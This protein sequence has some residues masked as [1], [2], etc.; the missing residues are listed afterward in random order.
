MLQIERNAG[1]R[2][3]KFG[4]LF[5]LLPWLVAGGCS[6]SAGTDSHPEVFKTAESA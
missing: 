1:F 3:T 2:A 6:G 5:L 4:G